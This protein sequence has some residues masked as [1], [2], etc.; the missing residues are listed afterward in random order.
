MHQVVESFV[1]WHSTG[2]A[3][4]IRYPYNAADSAASHA[5]TNSPDAAT[6]NLNPTTCASGPATDCSV[7]DDSGSWSSV[8][9]DESAG[10]PVC[11]KELPKT[12]Y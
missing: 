7:N 5:D 12:R 4:A 1:N 3:A 11:C 9:V 8:A 2:R 6:P 10:H